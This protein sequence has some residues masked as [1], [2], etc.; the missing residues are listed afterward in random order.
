MTKTTLAATVLAAIF[1]AGFA[2]SAQAQPSSSSEKQTTRQLNQEQLQH[3][4]AGNSG[5]ADAGTEA[6]TAP[7]SNAE[8]RQ[9][10]SLSDVPNAS[11]E[12]KSA[13]IETRDGARIGTVQSVDVNTD[14]TARAIKADVN[15]RE[16]SFNPENLVYLKDEN[17]LVTKTATPDVQQSQPA[18]QTY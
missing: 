9:A 7:P 8:L 10:V 12:L 16:V 18:G 14:G 5:S 2:L 17:T 13:A 6:S 11:A 1:A 3:P 15:G 4:G